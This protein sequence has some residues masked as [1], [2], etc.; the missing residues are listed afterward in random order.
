VA[1]KKILLVDDDEAVLEVLQAKLGA[2][3]DL[4]STNAAGKTVELA[5]REQPDLIVCD[6]DMPDMDG[7]DVSSA[8]FADDRVRHIPLLFLTALVDPE[9]LKLL[10]GQIGGRPALSKRSAASELAARIKELTE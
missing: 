10:K 1:R 3:F 5:I 6:V 2:H 8:L 9:D 7:G 4:V